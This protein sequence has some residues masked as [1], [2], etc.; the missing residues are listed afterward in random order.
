MRTLVWWARWIIHTQDIAGHLHPIWPNFQIHPVNS[1]H[2]F[3]VHLFSTKN[4]F[5]QPPPPPQK[6][7]DGLKS[8]P[9]PIN[10]G[11]SNPMDQSLQ[12]AI[13]HPLVIHLSTKPPFAAK[14][15]MDLGLV[16]RW[17]SPYF[18]KEKGTQAEVSYIGTEMFIS[19]CQ[20]TEMSFW[21]LY[22]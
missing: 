6:I 15:A 7:V 17:I 1:F 20:R 9:W 18:F 16:P 12:N 11:E 21:A 22:D 19:I 13:C 3:N 4:I 2:F 8:P 5:I 10:D 14:F